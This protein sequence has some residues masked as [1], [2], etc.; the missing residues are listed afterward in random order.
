M[1]LPPAPP[2]LCIL[3]SWNCGLYLFP[4][5]TLPIQHF[6]PCFLTACLTAS[7]PGAV[8]GCVIPAVVENVSEPPKGMS[9]AVTGAR[10]RLLVL[11]SSLTTTHPPSPNP[12]DKAR[13]QQAARVG[14][15]FLGSH[16]QSNSLSGLVQ[17]TLLS[18][19]HVCICDAEPGILVILVVLGC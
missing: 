17:G 2:P 5:A 13:R 12:S 4:Q 19:L 14:S 10:P 7:L 9:W 8:M 6:R 15:G 11:S 16:L 1:R 3:T 18:G